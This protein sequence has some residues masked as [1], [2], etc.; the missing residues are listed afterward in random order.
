ML[1]S[2]GQAGFLAYRIPAAFSVGLWQ[3][4]GMEIAGTLFDS[5]LR[6]QLRIIAGR[7]APDSLLSFPPVADGITCS[8][9][10]YRF[11]LVQIEIRIFTNAVW[12]N[13]KPT[14]SKENLML[15]SF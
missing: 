11:Y 8:Q 1:N 2:V 14:N 7:Q 6:V 4:N 15:I 10:K 3:T 12:W 5:Q 9:I 13:R